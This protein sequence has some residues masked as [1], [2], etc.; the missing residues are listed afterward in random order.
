MYCKT[1]LKNINSYWNLLYDLYKVLDNFDQLKKL[2][3]VLNIFLSHISQRLYIPR[4]YV[5]VYTRFLR[6]TK[7]LSTEVFQLRK[8][9]FQQSF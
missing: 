9:R 5:R 2:E 1:I 6:V 7:A 4:V 8:L 3:S